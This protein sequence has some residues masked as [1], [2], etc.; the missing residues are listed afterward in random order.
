MGDRVDVLAKFSY[1]RAWPEKFW[2]HG[3]EYQVVTINLIFQRKDGGR[4]YTCFAVSTATLE[5]ELDLD[6]DDLTWILRGSSG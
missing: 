5:V 1:G 6:R 3:R 4:K 2:W